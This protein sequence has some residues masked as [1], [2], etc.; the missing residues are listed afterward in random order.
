MGSKHDPFNGE[1][2][3]SICRDPTV[4]QNNSRRA[5]RMTLPRG[6]RERVISGLGYG[7][8]KNRSQHE[9]KLQ[10]KIDRESYVEPSRGASEIYG[11]L[12]GSGGMFH[13]VVVPEEYVLIHGQRS[14]RGE[15]PH[16]HFGHTHPVA[17]ISIDLL[18]GDK[19]GVVVQVQ[20]FCQPVVVCM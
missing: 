18:N 4:M 17:P 8:N 19:G 10:K 3:S 5:A 12:T 20:F 14:K 2:F 9:K 6:S 15:I 11:V 7:S 13:V 16:P 1:R